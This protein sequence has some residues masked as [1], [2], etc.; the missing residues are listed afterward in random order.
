MVVKGVEVNMVKLEHQ[1]CQVEQALR[2]KRDPQEEMDPKDSLDYLVGQVTFFHFTEKNDLR[3]NSFL[4]IKVCLAYVDL[5]ACLVQ[6][7]SLVRKDLEVYQ[8]NQVD[9]ETRDHLDFLA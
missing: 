5:M 9:K 7:E 4:I 1:E 3:N 2:E 8:E 6:K